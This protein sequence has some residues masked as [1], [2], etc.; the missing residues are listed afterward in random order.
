MK[1]G[2]TIFF[3]V[4]TWKV[5]AYIKVWYYS[6]YCFMGP[7]ELGMPGYHGPSNDSNIFSVSVFERLKN[8]FYVVQLWCHLEY[9]VINCAGT[10]FLLG[11]RHNAILQNM[12]F[13]FCRWHINLIQGKLVFHCD[14]SRIHEKMI[15]DC[16][17]K[18]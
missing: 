6:V 12:L 1:T 7:F 18:Y 4:L 9:P 17:K 10:Y 3:L 5:Y 14:T 13:F 8:V 15:A 16:E 2:N 11:C